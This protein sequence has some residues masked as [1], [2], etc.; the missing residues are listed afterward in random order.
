MIGVSCTDL[1]Q[2]P[3][4]VNLRVRY[5]VGIGV[6]IAFGSSDNESDPE[7][8]SYPDTDNITGS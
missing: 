6:I 4:S 5:G 1:G 2:S 3:I 7:A 8:G